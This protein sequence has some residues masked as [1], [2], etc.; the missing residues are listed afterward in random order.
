[1]IGKFG[2]V[3]PALLWAAVSAKD[4]RLCDKDRDLEVEFS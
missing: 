3:A 1:M 4:I 2:V